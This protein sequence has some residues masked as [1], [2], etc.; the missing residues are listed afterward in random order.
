MHNHEQSPERFAS[1][2]RQRGAAA[3]VVTLL[4]FFAM[5]LIAAF[6][7]RGLIFEQRSAANQARASVAF[8]AAEAGLEWAL[9]Q[10]NQGQSLDAS[11]R[12]SGSVG[13]RNFRERLLS[14]DA[15]TRRHTPVTW[16]NAGQAVALQPSCVR[17]GSGWA[18]SCPSAGHPVLAAPSTS[19]PAPAFSIQFAAGSERGTV[20]LRSTGC[21]H[22][23]GACLPGSAAT[24]DAT[25]RVQAV[26]GLVPG[27]ATPPTAPL[28]VQQGITVSPGA[29]LGLHNPDAGANGVVLHSGGPAHLA[30]A[31]LST[32]PGA[33]IATSIVSDD[34]G[35]RTLPRERLFA[36]LFGLD[37]SSW[38]DQPGLTRFVCNGSCAA[39]LQQALG[40][41][42]GTG[43]G[44]RQV[45]VEGDLRLEGAVVIGSPTRPVVLVVNG[46]ARFTGPVVVHGLVYSSSLRWD[47]ASSGAL[48]RGAVVSESSYFGD[49]SPDLFYDARVLAAL[50]SDSGSFV[51][52]PGSWKDF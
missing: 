23:G 51:R 24:V 3:L 32:A 2:H 14:F 7:N 37:T 42:Q 33:A 25:A 28:T 19:T 43:T 50:K 10:L 46:A 31:R 11:C 41:L 47:A 35:L 44:A 6:A 4:L 30:G 40:V 52:L 48:V 21:T 27:L 36:S 38:Q 49:A 9:A 39:A 13:D 45:W 34:S 18:C 1:A 22:L 20:L 8:E 16:N 17:Q 29:A 5:T 12:S 26:L 15:T